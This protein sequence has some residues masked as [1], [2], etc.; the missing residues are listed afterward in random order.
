MPS[1]SS[2]QLS[3]THQSAQHVNGEQHLCISTCPLAGG[4]GQS[5]V[6]GRIDRPNRPE[7]Q[8]QVFDKR[9][10]CQ[11]NCVLT[12]CPGNKAMPSES[13]LLT[14]VRP[15]TKKVLAL[16]TQATHAVPVILHTATSG[17]PMLPAVTKPCLTH[18]TST[19]MHLPAQQQACV[20]GLLSFLT[21]MGLEC[22]IL[23]DSFLVSPC[24][25]CTLCSAGSHCC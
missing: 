16:L 5:A 18:A 15:S 17:A 9:V 14:A 6:K 1:A 21:H 19:C 3:N 11:S 20:A 2:R 25:A 8:Q 13:P 22:C 7:E 10:N 4:R 23:C 12:A 24:D